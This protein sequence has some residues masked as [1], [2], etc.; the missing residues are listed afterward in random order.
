M[1]K[2][3]AVMLVAGLAL[4]PGVASAQ[5]EFGLKGGVTFADVPKFGE[6]VRDDDGDAQMRIGM[7]AGGH[8]AIAFGGIVGLQG[9]VL[10]TQKGIK[11]EA[12]GDVDQTFTL[13]LDYIDVPVLLRLGPSGGNGLQFL[14]GPSFNFNIGA[15]SVLEGFIDDDEDVKEEFKD[16]E[17]G[18]V[19][20]GGYYG[21]VVIVEGRWQEGLTDISAIR[22]SGDSTYRNRTF[23]ALV[24]VRFGG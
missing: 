5:V 3:I 18:L 14:V 22:E 24:G 10:Y 7:A 9:E 20:G 8:V 6:E 11:A 15:R 1:N 13:E 23:L 21:S 16:F 2:H 4:L 19:V 17:M 12:P